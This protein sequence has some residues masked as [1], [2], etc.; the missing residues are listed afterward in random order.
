MGSLSGVNRQAIIGMFDSQY[1][2]AERRRFKRAKTESMV[3]FRVS[4]FPN[5][6]I[7]AQ[8]GISGLDLDGVMMADDNLPRATLI[9]SRFSLFS[10]S[11]LNK[12]RNRLIWSK[13]ETRYS[14]KINEREYRFGVMFSNIANEDK[15]FIA[16]LV[17]WE[18]IRGK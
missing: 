6:S 16:N 11:P 15:L 18:S 13:G 3:S 8:A 2:G 12:E 5:G 1:T 14:K 4:S 9:T 10:D 7:Q 17:K